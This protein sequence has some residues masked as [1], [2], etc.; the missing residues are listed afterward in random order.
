MAHPSVARRNAV[1]AVQGVFEKY[2]CHLFIIFFL[3]IFQERDSYGSFVPLLGAIIAV[4][5][6][7]KLSAQLRTFNATSVVFFCLIEIPFKDFL[8][9]RAVSDLN[10]HA[11]CLNISKVPKIQFGTL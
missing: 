5:I 6:L 3:K 9:F 2:V 10:V 4:D 7:L 11:T 1:I 8:S